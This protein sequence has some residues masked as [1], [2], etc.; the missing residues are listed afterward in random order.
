MKKTGVFL[1]AEFQALEDKLKTWQKES[2]ELQR[3]HAKLLTKL[4]SQDLDAVRE[5][6]QRKQLEMDLE[7]SLSK[8]EQL[9]QI[10]RGRGLVRNI[11]RHHLNNSVF[12]ALNCLA[13]ERKKEV[14]NKKNRKSV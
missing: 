7:D 3:V 6:S 4:D 10:I 5:D 14:K 11:T 12:S 9:E 8:I 13:T 2:L 1:Q